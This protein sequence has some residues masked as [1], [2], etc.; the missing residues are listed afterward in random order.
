MAEGKRT[1]GVRVNDTG[2]KSWRHKYDLSDMEAVYRRGQWHS[3]DDIINWLETYGE[4]DNELTPGETV[5]I[6]EDLRS[7]RDARVPFT[8]KPSEAYDLVFKHGVG[9]G[10]SKAA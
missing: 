4:A 10:K 3:W 9:T 2:N 6:V 7:V 5:A 1:E 8:N